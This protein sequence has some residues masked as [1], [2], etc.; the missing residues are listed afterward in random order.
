MPY[1][2]K[3]DA[4]YVVELGV[5]L[6]ETVVGTD[7]SWLGAY[8]P[9]I[10]NNILDVTSMC[11]AGPPADAEWQ[12]ADAL[13]LASIFGAPLAYRKLVR[14]ATKE[15]FPAYCELVTVGELHLCDT[16][17]LTWSADADG[18]SHRVNGGAVPAGSVSVTATSVGPWDFW[19]VVGIQ[20]ASGAYSQQFGNI[21]WDTGHTYGPWD[22]TALLAAHPALQFYIQGY[23]ANTVGITFLVYCTS[24]ISAITPEHPELPT[25]IILP[26]LTTGS[27]D[28][29][30]LAADL[31]ALRNQLSVVQNYVTNLS[32]QL[33]LPGSPDSSTTTTPSTTQVVDG[34]ANANGVL[35]TLS[36]VPATIG[37]DVVDPRRLITLGRYTLGTPEGWFQSNPL[38]HD[39]TIVEPLP[40]GTTRIGVTV[41]PPVVAT[42][43]KLYADLGARPAV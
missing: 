15:I 2:R 33:L 34:L 24:T 40:L 19:G 29:S 20:D 10:G 7:A 26:P 36:E 32:S 21:H 31:A 22:V 16:L 3:P 6:A 38:E 30:G 13:L 11:R 28:I 18:D 25:D 4:P 35:I 12:P 43:T 23:S 39:L 8:I 5:A 17:A 14:V 9:T 1:Q 41:Y 42:V 37:V 27:T